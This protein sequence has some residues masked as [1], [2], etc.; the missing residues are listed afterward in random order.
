MICA[1]FAGG[2]VTLKALG[3][4][5]K[6]HKDAEVLKQERSVTPKHNGQECEIVPIVKLA[7]TIFS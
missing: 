5:L 2:A 6:T 1:L 7:V 4:A 3:G